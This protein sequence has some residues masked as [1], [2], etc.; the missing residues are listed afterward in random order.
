MTNRKERA[1]IAAHTVEI[2]ERREYPCGGD[3]VSIGKVLDAAIAGTRHYS[4]EDFASVFAE[5]AT[6]LETPPCPTKTRFRVENTTTLS[7]AKT[8]VEEDASR[9]VLCLNFASAKS[10]GGGFL[11]G[12]QAQEE[13]LARATGLYVCIKDV[14]S[15]YET[16]RSCGTPLY[17]DHM[18]YSP[19]V[20]VIR[21]D[22]DQLLPTPFAVS[23]ITAPAVNAGAVVDNYPQD[24]PRI[25]EVMQARI[26]RVLSLAV[27][28]EHRHLVLGAW[29]CGVFKNDIEKVAQW[30]YVQLCEQSI[31]S[32]AFETVIFAVL[33]HSDTEKFISPF[34]A[35][36]D[37]A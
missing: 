23:I 7:A 28:H 8:L 34:R 21:D 18:I 27:I 2:L 9:R 19:N 29:G 20:P 1:L 12:A 26:E 30:F 24:V 15:Y 32:Q 13:C 33:D 5:R 10:P 35:C 11:T 6:C 17:T 16:N 31:F 25:D 4:P 22:D 36:F 3:T 14:S 37:R